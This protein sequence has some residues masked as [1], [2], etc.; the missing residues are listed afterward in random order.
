MGMTAENVLQLWGD[1]IEMKPMEAPGPN[2]AEVWV[3]R[4]FDTV[5]TGETVVG[6]IDVPFVD[7]FT[8]EMRMVPEPDYAVVNTRV[9]V[10]TELLIFNG[11]VINWKQSRK[12]WDE[13]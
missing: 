6:T 7:P 1:P 8:G 4:Y 3:Y 10:T 9:R 13:F 5:S 2:V 11:Q 12:V